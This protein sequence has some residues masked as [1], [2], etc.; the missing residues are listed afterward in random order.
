[1]TTVVRNSAITDTPLATSGLSKILQTRTGVQTTFTLIT[2]F[3]LKTL[4]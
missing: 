4:K 2:P 3:L 1:M